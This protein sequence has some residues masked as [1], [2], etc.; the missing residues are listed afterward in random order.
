MA[1]GIEKVND[2]IEWVKRRLERNQV[3]KEKIEEL[4]ARVEGLRRRK[5]AVDSVILLPQIERDEPPSVSSL[6][7]D[8]RSHVLAYDEVSRK[9]SQE[10][11]RSAK[12]A[13]QKQLLQEQYDDLKTTSSKKVLELEDAVKSLRTALEEKD[14]ELALQLEQ[15][16]RDW[17]RENETLHK[18]GKALQYDE[19]T[20]MESEFRS[21]TNE[22]QAALNLAQQRQLTNGQR[23]SNSQRE[24]RKSQERAR[25]L[26]ADLDAAATA[27]S[28]LEADLERQNNRVELL[29]ELLAEIHDVDVET[30]SLQ[31]LRSLFV[32]LAQFPYLRWVLTPLLRQVLTRGLEHDLC[33]F[34]L[35]VEALGLSDDHELAEWVPDEILA[36]PGTITY[37]PAILS[38]LR[39]W[40]NFPDVALPNLWGHDLTTPDGI[41]AAYY[42]MLE[43]AAMDVSGEL[44]LFECTFIDYGTIDCFRW[45]DVVGWFGVDNEFRVVELGDIR[46]EGDRIVV[47]VGGEE[48]EVDWAVGQWFFQV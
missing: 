6:V 32:R 25:R 5:A 42:A 19:K 17:K 48:L 15:A 39:I 28:E 16:E 36:N 18:P 9:L 22:L 46:R 37:P 10:Q 41:M 38:W 23:L 35:Q 20:V 27:R 8:L 2:A 40:S 14:S 7:Q 3:N 44:V 45:R 34:I 31:E 13:I 4:S 47:P 33:Y 24:L 21:K 43:T 29:D 30:F 1:I 26:Q 11:E 12:V